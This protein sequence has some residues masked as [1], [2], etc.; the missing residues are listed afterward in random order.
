VPTPTIAP[1]LLD[2]RAC[3]RNFPGWAIGGYDL[4][5]WRARM[6][7]IRACEAYRLDAPDYLPS[8]RVRDIGNGYLSAITVRG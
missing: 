4:N 3:A 5:T 8:G 6:W 1:R 2:Q 7:A